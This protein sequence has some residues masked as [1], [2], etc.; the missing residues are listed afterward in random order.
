MPS[1]YPAEIFEVVDSQMHFEQY[2]RYRRDD[3]IT[4]IWGFRKYSQGLL[5]N[6]DK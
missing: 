6:K 1:W 4:A 5:H 3:E 2:F